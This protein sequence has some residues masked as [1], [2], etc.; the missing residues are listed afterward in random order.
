MSSRRTIIFRCLLVASVFGLSVFFGTSA[1]Q[2]ASVGRVWPAEQQVSADEVGHSRLD[3][4]L[5]KYVDEDGFVDYTSWQ[6]SRTDRRALLIYLAEIGRTSL[7]KPASKDAK[8][9]LWINAYN[10]VTI[11][12]ILRVYPT[13]SIRN[14]TSRTF[15]YNIW[16]DLPLTVGGE[17]FSLEDIEHKILRK[18]GEPRIH[19]AIVCASV[20]CPRLRAEAYT[21]AKMPKQLEDNA[22]DFFNRSQ[23][24]QLTSKANRIH[25]SKI[26]DWFGEDFGSTQAA[27]LEAIHP[28]LPVSAQQI[29]DTGSAKVSYL[30]YDWNLNDQ[31]SKPR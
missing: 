13:S 27:Q 21:T 11:E 28:Y 29:V 12:G 16:Q 9:A 19:F 4:L 10:A 17:E 7:S 22:R 25:L 24:L 26:L 5:K 20:G 31:K 1:S 23:N 3:A 8:L 30:E 15:G 6:K 2:A 14:H 18:L